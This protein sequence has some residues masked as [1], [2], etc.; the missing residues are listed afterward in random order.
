MK[1]LLL[2]LGIAGILT[3]TLWNSGDSTYIKIDDD[4]LKEE[5]VVRAVK[6]YI[7]SFHYSPK[8]LD[9]SVSAEIYTLYLERIDGSKRFLTQEDVT[10]LEPYRY[11]IDDEIMNH[12][13]EFFSLSVE[14]IKNAMDRSRDIYN[15]VVQQDFSF[16]VNEYSELNPEKI[17]FA[18]DEEELKEYWRKYIKADILSRV[19]STLEKQ[20]DDEYEDEVL[21][22][23][24]VIDSAS[25]KSQESFEKWWSNV[26]K[27]RRSDWFSMYMNSIANV[28]DPHTSFLMPKDKDDFDLRLSRRLEGIGAQLT[29]DG[30]YTKVVQLV[31]GGPAWKQKKLKTDDLILKVEQEGETAVDVVGMHIDDVVSMIR[32]EKGSK[33]TL[34][35]KHAD[36]SHEEIQ[37]ERDV[38]EFEEGYAKSMILLDSAHNQKIGY[39]N[40]PSFYTDFNN[41]DARTSSTDVKMELEKLKNDGVN[42]VILDLRNNGGGS[43][44]DVVDMAGLFIEDGPIVQ[45]KSRRGKP[46]VLDDTDPAVVYEGP[47][48]VLV[49]HFSASASEIMAAAMQDYGRGII[50]GTT[51]TFGKGTVQ[52]IYDLDQGV[53]GNKD[54]KPL[55]SVK[56]T[57]QKY[58]RING[59]SVQLHGVTP[60][61]ILPDKYNLIDVGE[62]DYK[63]YMD[64]SEIPEADFSQDV[65][66]YDIPFLKKRSHDRVAD[67]HEFV[68][69]EEE[70]QYIKQKREETMI[71]LDLDDF[72]EQKEQDKAK[73]KYF[74]GDEAPIAGLSI[75]NLE[76]DIA[77][78]EADS[79]SIAR[80][81][82][83]M[84]DLHKDIY[85]SEALNIMNDILKSGRA[86]L[87]DN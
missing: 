78:I 2:T 71:A 81:E 60:D 55:G 47:L 37:I 24:A 61:I 77:H 20:E 25:V 84:K 59:G 18:A 48:I 52:R 6:Q 57:T 68:L 42:G 63:Y 50:V 22:L 11:Q 87:D 62:K 44:R 5:V 49:N 30:N 41:K 53:R 67:E 34:H 82:T 51:S 31:P 43:L 33:V 80:N 79:T 70:A 21:P 38:I 75:S 65:Y 3:F 35:V 45:V 76:V 40:L 17:D 7:E 39:I 66:S 16:D 1:T 46:Y 58:Y 72:R 36:G 56:I 9:D 86:S 14:T 15:D 73:S 26:D 74:K 64:W 10:V 23:D 28:F 69:I 12:K 83:L 27:I 19:V 29:M 8:E 13:V 32:G 54:L 85:I 4:A